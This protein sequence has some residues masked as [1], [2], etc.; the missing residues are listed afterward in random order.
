MLYVPASNPR[1]IEKARGLDCD[2]VV[3]DL[4][5]AVAPETKAQAR[6]TA[7]QALRDGGFG[8]RELVVRVNG[9]DTPW[10]AD[11]LA[12]LAESPAHA[13]LA[14]KIRHADDVLAYDAALAAARPELR[15]WVM[16]ETTRAVLDLPAIAATAAQTRQSAWVFGSNDLA[17]EMRCVLDHRRL[18]LAALLTLTVAAAR[19]HG[20]AVLD[21]V[22]NAFDDDTGLQAQCQQG[23]EYGFDGKTLIHPRQI[24][25]ANR[26]F[27][28]SPEALA[29]ALR[30]RAAFEQPEHRD[31]GAI[32]VDGAMVERLHLDEAE[33]LLALD[34]E[35]RLRQS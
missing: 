19:A 13:V 26:A 16:I 32:R 23:V 29:W 3:F 27:S 24:A 6:D 34:A 5:D 18:P 11:D 35:I 4:E 33:R 20:L 31:K 30:I 2:A 12:A 25:A 1:A 10:G 17:K 7:L 21:G 28:P 22:Y 15:L 8:A 14:P 9:L